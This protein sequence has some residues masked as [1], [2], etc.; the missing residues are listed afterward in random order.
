MFLRDDFF[1]TH[2]LERVISH[3]LPVFNCGTSNT[4]QANVSRLD[5]SAHDKEPSVRFH[6]RFFRIGAETDTS[7]CKLRES[8]IST[9]ILNMKESRC[10]EH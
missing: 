9:C 6:K 2:A 5:M 4:R 7:H 3:F 1:V 8:I 10:D